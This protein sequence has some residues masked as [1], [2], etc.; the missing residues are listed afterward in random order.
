MSSETSSIPQ[1]DDAEVKMRQH[2]GL[3]APS[4]LAPV[5]LSS[6][7]P[8]RGA[9][10]AIRSQAIAREYVERQL[11]HAEAT[12]QD[13]R[14]KLHH[15]RQE[16]DTAVEA[17]RSATAMRLSVQ[18]ALITTE[19][20]LATEK[21]ARDHGDRALREARATINHLQTKPDAA[22][23]GLETVR[24]ELAAERQAR[25]K[26][27]V[28]LAEV[29]TAPQIAVPAN[30]DEAAIPTIRRSVGRPR[31]VVAV[32]PVSEPHL[33]VEATKAPVAEAIRVA[34]VV[35]PAR[36]PVGR[37]RMTGSAPPKPT[38]SNA[39]SK[40][41]ALPETPSKKTDGPRQTAGEQEPVQWWVE[42]WNRR[43]K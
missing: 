21:A 38:S 39:A 9:R 13:L 37:P 26:A 41:A 30:P 28:A 22:A 5:P 20:A 14:T 34:T 17:A 11:A 43:K 10:Q 15:A 24:A 1:S 8:L 36:R 23:L 33:P 4:N 19:A 40:A 31:K 29:K 16:K 27:E 35:P 32:Q 3:D 42:G 18:R 2:L 7:D 6:N 12:I 25:Q